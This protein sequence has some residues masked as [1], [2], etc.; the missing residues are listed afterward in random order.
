MPMTGSK[1]NERPPI[2]ARDLPEI[3]RTCQAN[4]GF[5]EDLIRVYARLE[6]HQEA[7]T[8]RCLGGG[9]C[10]KFDLTG[11]KL[12]ASSG[13]LALLCLQPPPSATRHRPGRCCYQR[14][15]RCAARNRRPLGCRM[16]FCQNH[17]GKN[18]VPHYESYHRLIRHLH[19][20]YCLPYVYVDALSA[21]R[22]WFARP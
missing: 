20:K 15:P 17:P 21:M 14:G 11:Q 4:A 1:P 10:C 2:A 9:A 13:E 18:F 16:F 6:A 19:Q 3:I 22:Q 8:L 5:L 7:H 12:Y